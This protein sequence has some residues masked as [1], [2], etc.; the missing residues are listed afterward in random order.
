[1][2]RNTKQSD[3][4]SFRVNM[5][6]SR[7]NRLREMSLLAGEGTSKWSNERLALEALDRY[8][9]SMEQKFLE[10]RKQSFGQSGQIFQ[11][12]GDALLKEFLRDK[13]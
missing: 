8:T 9:G 2:T 3:D 6:S 1:M 7:A 12:T 13:P 4:L 11:W 5:S 10:S